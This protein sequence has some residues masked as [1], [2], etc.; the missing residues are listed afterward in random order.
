MFPII[1]EKLHEYAAQE[2]YAERSIG[3]EKMVRCCDRSFVH[4]NLCRQKFVKNVYGEGVK[5]VPVEHLSKYV[6]NTPDII[7]DLNVLSV[8]HD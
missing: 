7:V 8:L 5:A 4:S 3:A 1:V 6:L 2:V